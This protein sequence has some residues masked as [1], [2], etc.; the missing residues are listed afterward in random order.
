MVNASKGMVIPRFLNKYNTPGSYLATLSKEA[1][2]TRPGIE[3]GRDKERQIPGVSGDLEHQE[4]LEH[5]EHPAGQLEG[6]CK[7]TK[8]WWK[9]TPE[10]TAQE[11]GVS[12]AGARGRAAGLT[13][14]EAGRRLKVF[15]ENRL[16]RKEKLSPLRLFF[17]E[18]ADFMVLVLL[19][20]VIISGAL[21]E[22]DDAFT[23]LA[24]VFLNA[25]LGFVQEYKAERSL[26]ALKELSAPQARVLR[27]GELQVIPAV[28]VV[29]GDLLV[30]ETGDRVAAD[31]RLV[32]AEGLEVDESPL[33]GESLPVAKETAPLLEENPGLGE[34]RN[35]VQAG[36]TITRGRAKGLVVATGMNTELGKIA[37]L[38]EASAGGPTPLQKRL[39]Q[40]GK[41]LVAS[42]IIICVCVGL[43]GLWRGES[44]RSMF[45]SAVSL[46]VAAIPEGLPAIVTISLALGVQ[47][48]IKRQV[49]IRQLPA[50]ETLGC[51]SVICS[52]KTGTLT[53][54]QM[55]VTAVFL[56]GEEITVT[57]NGFTPYGR[58]YWR[59]KPLAPL[60]PLPP[61]GISA[62]STSPAPGAPAW[63][64][65]MAWPLSMAGET[66]EEGV[67][68]EGVMEEGGLGEVSYPDRE[69][70]R[71]LLKTGLVCNNAVLTGDGDGPDWK[72]T[73][74]PTEGALI[75]LARKMGLTG[76]ED[77]R[78][79]EI[80]F[81]PERKRMSVVVEEGGK[82]I[83]YA[84]GAA[85]L[86][87]DL[88][89]RIRWHGK[90]VP[91]QR[92]HRQLIQRAVESMADRALRVLALAYR[93]LPGGEKVGE[94]AEKDLVFLGLVGMIDPPRPEVKAAIRICKQAGI[95]TV[96]ITGDFPG[97]ARAIGEELGLLRPDGLIL[98]GAQLDR[99]SGDELA[100]IIDRVDI[101]ARVNPYHKLQVVQAFKKQGKVVAM[102]GDGVNDAPAVKEAQ[103]GVAMGI[104][105]TDVTKEASDMVIADDNF[106][107]IVAAVEEGRGIYSNIK[108]FLRYLLG[109]NTGE[110]ITMFLAGA[111]GIPFPLLPIQ[112]LWI[113]LV[114]DGLPAVALSMEPAEE[115]LMRV[116]PR[117]PEES[118]FSHG[119]GWQ[120]L[121]QGAVI[122]LATVLLFVFTS[123]QGATLAQARTVAFSALVF[124]QLSYAF[125]CRSERGSL[126]KGKPRKTPPLVAA[127]LL[128][129]LMQL[130]VVY[131]PFLQKIF[132]TSPLA[133][134]DW[135]LVAGAAVLSFLATPLAKA[136]FA[137][138]AGK[139]HVASV[140]KA[141][142]VG[143][144]S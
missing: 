69:G 36:T 60:G 101:F 40:L 80:P 14:Q 98:T 126:R 120:I 23:I 128:S 133:M 107:T 32:A 15:G 21:G 114:T 92:M 110:I 85:D 131:L 52:D 132:R 66:G 1:F 72:V 27:G 94:E 105:G 50:V 116:P 137:R 86:L 71:L 82:A 70:L 34:R 42:C 74:D 84:K 11:L 97:T 53:R 78:R 90:E 109:C 67:M 17:S 89:D 108:K 56:G 55:M 7:L 8:R 51:A 135:V 111:A 9:M 61:P 119:M 20:A 140:E 30:L 31:A 136:V 68:I 75:A 113:N 134:G 124:S 142:V 122:G 96:M 73:G 13:S 118:I 59:G 5:L 103:I 58:L 127:V 37:G 25:I 2:F 57:G 47:R 117:A 44:F 79:Q 18:F 43:L 102:T 95:R 26:Q 22:W 41:V 6:V 87:L 33:T 81:T 63:P 93:P 49:I 65:S 77:R 91:L 10:E 39:D 125:V 123:L 106:A 76:A 129:S 48:M 35:M 24:I 130:S 100:R 144:T 121:W 46:A 143:E 139:R 112:I 28:E 16:Q 138:I 64:S 99:V 141:Q 12:L 38:L 45:L 54:N 3:L 62:H 104:S 29:P 88:S 83:L 115:E 4:Y 19:G